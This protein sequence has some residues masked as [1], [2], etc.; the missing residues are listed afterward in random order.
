M[1]VFQGGA[2][3]VGVTDK[4]KAGKKLVEDDE[5]IN[6]Y[7]P[8]GSK[9][10]D[11]ILLA[12]E[13]DFQCTEWI[14]EPTLLVT[15][16][17]YANLFHTFTDW[18]SAY[19][20]S[21]VTCLTI[22]P[23][24]VFVDGHCETQLEEVWKAL[25]AS[26]RYAKHFKGPVCFRHAIL[27]PL[28]YE[29][30]LFKG[31]SENINCRGTTAHDLLQNPKDE[32]KT[33]RLDEFGEMIKAAFGFP[34]LNDNP[35]PEVSGVRHH[36]ILFVR[37]EDYLAHPR[38]SGKPESRLS[39][40]QQ[41][42]DAIRN[43]AA[44]L[45]SSSNGFKCKLSV[46]NGLFGHMSVKEQVE[47]IQDASVIVGAHGAGMTHAISAVP[48]TIILEIISSAHRRPHFALIAK[49]KGL[50]YQPIFLDGSH[51]DPQVVID[52]LDSILKSS[53]LG[54]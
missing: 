27:S 29:T 16:Y 47:A 3:D 40:E 42:F 6:R 22:R 12:S 11:S 41:V 2:F 51:A 23:H 5:F 44:S 15:R 13:D 26:V 54:C 9:L 21:R 7:L 49:W 43:W 52:K 28:G 36:S 39:N 30:A 32:E 35:R 45:L 8:Q 31:L 33:S 48:G 34:P 10:I 4:S 19:V 1:P 38:H 25:F 53:G 50:E 37:R 18:Y 14:E 24:V 20:T 17:E 46:V